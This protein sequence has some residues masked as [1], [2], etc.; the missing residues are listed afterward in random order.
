MAKYRKLADGIIQTIKQG[1]VI[2]GDKLPSLRQ[3]AQQHGVSLSTAIS[4]YEELESQGWIQAR[5]KSGYF[6][7]NYS[8][9]RATPKWAQFQSQI[10]TATLHPPSRQAISGPLGVASTTLSLAMPKNCNAAL[11]EQRSVSARGLT[12]IPV[13]LAKPCSEAALPT[14]FKS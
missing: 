13:L 2:T 6:I 11:R 12:S 9:P 5:P 10:T 3:F 8:K 14:I 7:A 1:K 4:C